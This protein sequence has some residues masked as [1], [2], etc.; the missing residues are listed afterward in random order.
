[1]YQDAE[2]SITNVAMTV[3]THQHSGGVAGSGR[4]ASGAGGAVSPAVAPARTATSVLP[5]PTPPPRGTFWLA[6][7]L[8]V[9]T[10]IH[11][12]ILGLYTHPGL[13]RKACLRHLVDYEN[14]IFLLRQYYERDPYVDGGIPPPPPGIRFRT[15]TLPWKVVL[16][17]I[18]STDW[19]PTESDFDAIIRT[20]MY[21]D[22]PGTYNTVRF[23]IETLTPSQKV[24]SDLSSYFETG[25]MPLP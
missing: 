21:Y 20:V 2:P 5:D 22:D 11:P 24:P 1:M 9:N 7:C 10:E 16:E 23:Y 13:A 8:I 3:S 6:M 14:G 19:L 25:L 18:R 4:P 15:I 17:M 12:Q